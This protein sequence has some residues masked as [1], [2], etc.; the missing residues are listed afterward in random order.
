MDPDVDP[1]DRALLGGIADKILSAIKWPTGVT[2]RFISVNTSLMVDINQV[3]ILI[4]YE[5]VIINACNA[6]VIIPLADPDVFDKINT[7][8]TGVD[9]QSS[10]NRTTLPA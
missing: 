9:E 2:R 6:T 8:L 5:Y 1:D 4:D 3:R 10:C 7:I